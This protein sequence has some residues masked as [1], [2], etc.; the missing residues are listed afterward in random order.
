MFQLQSVLIASTC[1]DQSIAVMNFGVSYHILSDLYILLE[2]SEN[3][4]VVC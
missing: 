4:N 2:Q 1:I 3:E